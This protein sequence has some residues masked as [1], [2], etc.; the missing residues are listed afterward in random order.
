M[1]SIINESGMSSSSNSTYI[2]N[3][4][5]ERCANLILTGKRAN[6]GNHK[7]WRSYAEGTA[8][9]LNLKHIVSQMDRVKNSMADQSEPLNLLSS[10]DE[11][12]QDFDEDSCTFDQDGN[13][14]DE[15][16]QPSCLA[17]LTLAKDIDELHRIV[18]HVLCVYARDVAQGYSV[19][20]NGYKMFV[21]D[22]C[23]SV[24]PLN[25]RLLYCVDPLKN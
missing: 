1:S 19:D 14:R 4:V 21:R 20:V 13:R 12:D 9:A 3:V 23:D 10:D 11:E 7:I 25:Q 6:E 24:S 8:R 5:K 16:K 22:P 17:L 2:E 15:A 18:R